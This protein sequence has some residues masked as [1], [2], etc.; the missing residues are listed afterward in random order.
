MDEQT[1]E[2]CDDGHGDEHDDRGH[3]DTSPLPEFVICP[4]GL[5][6]LEELECP[7][8]LRG[9]GAAKADAVQAH[10][11]GADKGLHPSARAFSRG[12]VGAVLCADSC[13]ISPT[14]RRCKFCGSAEA[15]CMAGAPH[16]AD[17]D[18]GPTFAF[19]SA[20]DRVLPP[21]VRAA[22]AAFDPQSYDAASQA[23]DDLDRHASETVGTI[24][25]ALQASQKSAVF[26]AC[27]KSV[28]NPAVS[29]VEAVEMLKNAARDFEES[30]RNAMRAAFDA[31]HRRAMAA[32]ND[33]TSRI[34]HL[35]SFFP[36]IY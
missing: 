30:D 32:G 31:M 26:A 27:L 12:V 23:L 18:P 22:L 25:S 1:L 19:S 28:M 29:I 15:I 35:T 16:D 5:D 8:S 6:G 20:P 36:S 2:L 14:T 17:P 13:T 7:D 10:P 3:D 21:S 11:R 34:Q 24:N 4:E 9:L 33:A